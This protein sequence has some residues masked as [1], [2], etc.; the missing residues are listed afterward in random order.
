MAE[1]IKYDTPSLPVTEISEERSWKQ[2][3]NVGNY[4]EVCGIVYVESTNLT[5]GGRVTWDGHTVFDYKFSANKICANEDD[6][7]K[8][9]ELIPALAEFK[10][11]IDEVLKVLGKIPAKV[12]NLCLEIY[13]IVWKDKTLQACARIDITLICWLG[14]CAWK[15][16]QE[17]GCFTI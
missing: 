14:K 13:N 8:L 2:C 15:G 5:I 4:G 9:I 16:T 3:F 12:F 7:L 6:L 10:P 1:D 17:L 11:V